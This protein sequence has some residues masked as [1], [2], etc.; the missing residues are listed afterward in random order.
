MPFTEQS[1]TYGTGTMDNAQ[2]DIYD[3]A[4]TQNLT[5]TE[6][7]TSTIKE[8]ILK[9]LNINESDLERIVLQES[10]QLGITENL[11]TKIIV[12]GINPNNKGEFGLGAFDNA[13][14]GF[15]P[16][17]QYKKTDVQEKEEISIDEQIIKEL[18]LEET[19]LNNITST[20]SDKVQFSETELA[21][22]LTTENDS[23]NFKEMTED[24][25]SGFIIKLINEINKKIKLETEIKEKL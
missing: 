15:T 19:D 23:V 25:I 22:L 5:M 11:I 17:T 10:E 21:N 4:K 6:Q 20:L 16:D 13:E 7:E 14:F 3:Y 1:G 24:E 8:Q 2:F 9:N 18:I 12:L